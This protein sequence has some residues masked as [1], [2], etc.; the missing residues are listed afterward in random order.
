MINKCLSC[1]SRIVDANA[2]F[3]PSVQHQLNTVHMIQGLYKTNRFLSVIYFVTFLASLVAIGY[4]IFDEYFHKTES[5]VSKTTMTDSSKNN[6]PL[7]SN[8]PERYYQIKDMRFRVIIYYSTEKDVLDSI[9]NAYIKNEDS[10]ENYC[11]EGSDVKA[12]YVNHEKYLLLNL[13]K[14]AT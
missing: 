4:F 7:E 11:M 3:V 9:L 5:I 13:A 6:K 8:L 12:V 1:G 14:M 2:N 10:P